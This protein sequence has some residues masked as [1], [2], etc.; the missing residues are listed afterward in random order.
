MSEINLKWNR[1][2]CYDRLTQR[3]SK[4]W[5]NTNCQYAYN[6]H[7]V[8]T[9][10]FQPGGTAIFSINHMSHKVI[11]THSQDATGLGRWISTLYQGKKDTKLRI[12]QVYRPCKPNPNSSNGVYQQH[13]RYFLSK[14]N[15][16]SPRT[17]WL[18]DLHTFITTCIQNSEQIIVMGDFNDDVTTQPISNFFTSLQMHNLLQTLFSTQYCLF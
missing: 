6:A 2:S 18:S 3:A 12:I 11:P 13:S 1:F 15:V 9:A 10:K 14:H 5:E 7:D 16:T 4:W 8:S 17:Q